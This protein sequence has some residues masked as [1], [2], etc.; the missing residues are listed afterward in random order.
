MLEQDSTAKK[1]T[2]QILMNWMTSYA[3]GHGGIHEITW[4]D[5]GTAGDGQT[6]TATI[7]YADTTTS[8]FVVKDGY[9]GD[10]GD[11]WYTYIKYA[12]D[13]PTDDGDIGDNPDNYIGLYT[14][15]VATAPEHYSDYEWFQW[16]GDKG[17]TGDAATITAQSVGYL[18]SASGTTPPEGQWATTVP[19][20]AQGEFL[21]TRTTIAYNTG[22]IVT[23]YS[24]ARSGID[25][26]GSVSAVNTVSPD[27]GGNVSLTANDI[28]TSDT[29]SVQDHITQIETNI[30]SIQDIRHYSGTIT[31]FPIVFSYTNITSDH[32]VI[33]CSFGTPSALLGDVSWTT[34]AGSVTFSG[35]LASGSSTTIDF[36]IT[37]PETI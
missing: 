21:W 28:P 37:K 4:V 29:D 19:A 36:D 17:D 13:L 33:N 14:G 9:K 11:T 6:H 15:A 10:K 25:G 18:T 7:H 8:T 26:A 12:S 27:S 31:A 23:A 24:V 34:A 32:R 5:S 3:D 22:D 16:K 30:S 1:L 20:V 35:T 2:G